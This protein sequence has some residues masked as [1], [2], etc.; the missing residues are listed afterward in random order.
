MAQEKDSR[1]IVTHSHN[2]SSVSPLLSLF[3]SLV[4]FV[5]ILCCFGVPLLSSSCFP[6]L[7]LC[8]LPRCL[9]SPWVLCVSP[10]LTVFPPFLS[11]CFS[12]VC[13]RCSPLLPLSSPVLYFC[14]S[15]T[16]SLLSL[17]RLLCFYLL[18]SLLCPLLSLFLLSFVYEDSA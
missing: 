9:G 17:P 5:Y 2:I 4:V 13:S 11:L 18:F 7:R 10:L 12:P 16:C 3:L 15:L 6:L 1:H 8:F 14:F